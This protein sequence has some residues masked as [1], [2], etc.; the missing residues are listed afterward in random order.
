MGARG[1][2]KATAVWS[3]RSGDKAERPSSRP[4][5]SEGGAFSPRPSSAPS[6]D[7]QAEGLKGVFLVPRYDAD[8]N[9]YTG[10]ADVYRWDL[11]AAKFRKVGTAAFSKAPPA[12]LP[13]IASQEK[14]APPPEEIEPVPKLEIRAPEDFDAKFAHVIREFW[15]SQQVSERR[16]LAQAPPP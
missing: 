12:I 6:A 3:A 4:L 13:P 7:D 10:L 1:K 15:R 16:E 8:K 9:E 2:M 5:K 14:L 11:K